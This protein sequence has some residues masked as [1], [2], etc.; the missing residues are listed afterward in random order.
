MLNKLKKM[1][2]SVSE[3]T[4]LLIYILTA[5]AVLLLACFLPLAFRGDSIISPDMMPGERAAMYLKYSSGDKTIRY[6][7]DNDPD[8]A[9]VK[10]C[11]T[12][13][14]EI[15][16]RTVL[17]DGLRKSLATGC[18]YIALTDGDNTMQL[19]RMWL[20]DQGDW[21]NWIDVYMDAETGF[22]YYFYASSICISNNDA[23]Y[24][25]VT[26]ELSAK[27]LASILAKETEYDLRLV[28]WSGNPEDSAMAYST[29]NGDALVWNIYC[30][31]YPGSML[32]IKI[33]VG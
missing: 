11:E 9:Q 5:T 28:N 24:N 10:F 6:K 33:S 27:T 23:Y 7:I 13:F 30:S 8:K 4:K 18:E 14:N 32:D 21:T 31:Y 2:D 1:R 17:D 25:A 26:D 12:R 16:S 3:K 22:V 15:V 20:Q 19:C 29:R